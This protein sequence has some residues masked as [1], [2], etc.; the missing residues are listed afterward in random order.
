LVLCVLKTLGRNLA[1][2][3]VKLGSNISMATINRFFKKFIKRFARDEY[4]RSMALPAEEDLRI[5]LQAYE[6]LGFPGCIGSIDCTHV[7]WDSVPH[8][9]AQSHTDRHSMKTRIFQIAVTHARRILSVSRGFPGSTNDK[10]VCSTDEFIH[11]VRFKHPYNDHTFRLRDEI[12]RQ[13]LHS[14]SLDERVLES[15]SSLDERVF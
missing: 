7:P 14:G 1:L 6:R 12:G 2:I 15:Q 10:T 13:T 11:N 3:E 4:N 5:I 8:L 9:L